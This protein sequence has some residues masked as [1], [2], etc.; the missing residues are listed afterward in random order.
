MLHPN[1]NDRPDATA[2]W[3]SEPLLE[4]SEDIIKLSN[5]LKQKRASHEVLN[6]TFSAI[7]ALSRLGVDSQHFRSQGAA[8]LSMCYRVGAARART[9]ATPR[10]NKTGESGAGSPARC[11]DDEDSGGSARQTQCCRR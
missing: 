11:S 4:F 9:I 7:G 8:P 5:T 10:A 2:L 1:E 3:D 6:D